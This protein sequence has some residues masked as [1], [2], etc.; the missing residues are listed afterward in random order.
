MHRDTVQ[1]SDFYN[2]NP[3]TCHS[4]LKPDTRVLKYHWKGFNDSQRS[5]VLLEQ[6]RMRQDRIAADNLEKEKERLFAEQE[7]KVRR[8][9]VK[10][11]RA[12]ASQRNNVAVDTVQFNKYKAMEDQQ[13]SKILYDDVHTFKI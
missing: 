6:E 2:E 8:D 12:H 9:L 10:M 5:G 1:N 3:D 13:R 7:E 4:T 11:Q